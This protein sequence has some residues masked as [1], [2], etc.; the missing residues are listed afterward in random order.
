L[1]RSRGVRELPT[2][3]FLAAPPVRLDQYRSNFKQ[4]HRH[5]CATASSDCRAHRESELLDSR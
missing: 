1:R 2:H 5:D 3:L 4:D